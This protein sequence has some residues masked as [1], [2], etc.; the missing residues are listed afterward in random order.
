MEILLK[1]QKFRQK[2]KF[3]PKN[4]ICVK[5]RNFRHKSKCLPK[6]QIFVKSR[7]LPKNPNFRHKLKFLPKIQISA[8]NLTFFPKIEIFAKNRNFRQKSKFSPKMLFIAYKQFGANYSKLWLCERQTRQKSY[9]ACAATGLEI[10]A[11]LDDTGHSQPVIH[12]SGHSQH[13]CKPARFRSYPGFAEY[14]GPCESYQ[15][16]RIAV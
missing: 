10:V 8:K 14:I 13:D 3:L 11:D 16:I 15:L 4:A 5:N 2:S 9:P 7:N 6:I 1:D 12:A